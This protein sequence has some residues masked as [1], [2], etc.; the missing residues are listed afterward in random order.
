MIGVGLPLVDRHSDPLVFPATEMAP[1][2]TYSDGTIGV[3]AGLTYAEAVVKMLR[4]V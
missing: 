2:Y 1:N 4:A 3:F